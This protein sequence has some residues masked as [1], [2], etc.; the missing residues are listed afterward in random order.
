MDIYIAARDTRQIV[1]YLETFKHLLN[2][3]L[4]AY[5]LFFVIKSIIFI[6]FK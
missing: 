6:M 5:I 1:K 3:F 4:I 2:I